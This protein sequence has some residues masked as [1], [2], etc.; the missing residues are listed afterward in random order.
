M[1]R[2]DEERHTTRQDGES[3]Q[4]NGAARERASFTDDLDAWLREA[5]GVAQA[6]AQA[7]RYQVDH[8]LRE[9]SQEVT[10][11]VYR[12]GADGKDRI[13]PFVRKRFREDAGRGYAYLQILR[14]QTRGVILQHQPLIYDCERAGESLDV[15]ME[16][17]SGETLRD[18]AMREGSGVA[19]A[20]RIMP[21]L[22][23]AVSELHESFEQ[24][25][26]HRD[27]KPSNVIVNGDRLKL[28]DLGIA[29]TYRNDAAHDTMQYGTPGYAPPEQYGYGQTSTRSDVYA[30][31]MTLAFCLTGEDPTADLREHLLADPRIPQELRPALSK[32]TEF[33]PQRRYATAREFKQDLELAFGVI[34]GKETGT[35]P[36]PGATPGPAIPTPPYAPAPDPAPSSTSDT[37][38]ERPQRFTVLGRIWNGLLVVIWVVFGFACVT[39]SIDPPQDM[40]E[41][42]P[43]WLI[44]FIFLVFFYGPVSC[45]VYLLLDKRR[46]RKHEPFS[47]YT[48]RNEL[49]VCLSIAFVCVAFTLLLK[50]VLG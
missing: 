31:G 29:R 40:L 7:E 25:L 28:I 2:S 3:E 15:V 11:V 20:A 49:P 22:C 43:R 30:L 4:P 26:I 46:L 17:L 10:E 19:F 36:T 47:R 42:N 12:Y 37:R 32:A 34:R 48:W 21:D 18:L 24:P 45:L 38:P 6:T 44:P 23:D 27:V 5:S 50:F 41:T 8:V 14:A 33:D 1:A 13:G 39:S 16:Y 35:Q 9:T